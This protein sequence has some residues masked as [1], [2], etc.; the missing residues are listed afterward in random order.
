MKIAVIGGGSSY[1]PELIDGLIKRRENLVIDEIYLVDIPA[2]EDKLNIV[3]ALAKRMLEKHKMLT[4]VHLTLNRK[5]GIKDADFII[6]QLRVGGLEARARDEQIPLRYDLI[7]QE[8]TGAGGFAKALRTIPVILDICKDIEHYAKKDAWLINFTNPAGIITET[9]L[10]HTN[11]K[12]LG[13]CNVPIA[14]EKDMAE[15]MEVSS[16]RLSIDFMG[17]NHLVYGKKVYVDGEDVTDEVVEKIKAG[18]SNSMNNIPDLGWDPMLMSSL[19]MVLCPY[20]RYYY[21]TEELLNDEKAKDQT[22]AEE[23]MAIEKELFAVYKDLSLDEKPKAL[24]ERGGAYYSEVAVS[25][26]DAIVNN[27]KEVHT[28]NVMNNG[29]ISNMPDDVVV[30]VGALITKAGAKPLPVGKLPITVLGLVQ[31]VKAYEQLT[32]EAGV[33]GDEK[34][35]LQALYNH[36]LVNSFEKSKSLLADILRENMSYLPQ[37]KK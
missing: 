32:I 2:G 30:E 15:I 9:V 7:G 19:N 24:E 4:K 33:F 25:L 23:V 37:F 28:V 22:R 20:H 27:K 1:T 29:A 3:G 13:L 18:A 8:T 34:A 6:T 10:K 12:T 5:E 21:M 36:P 16:G 17:L 35:A 26:I 11:V 14:M 31:Q